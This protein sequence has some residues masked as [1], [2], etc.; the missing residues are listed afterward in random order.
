MPWILNFFYKKKSFQ[1]ICLK[2]LISLLKTSVFLSVFLFMFSSK[3]DFKKR[4]TFARHLTNKSLLDVG[5]LT[6]SL[7][8]K[9]WLNAAVFVFS[10]KTDEWHGFPRFL[11]S[12]L[13]V[14]KPIDEFFPRAVRKLVPP[15]CSALCKLFPATNTVSSGLSLPAASVVKTQ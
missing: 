10:N 1:I 4:K 9:K 15:F 11:K 14:R 3:E 2:R 7:H 5:N 12:S 8:V 6:V 13:P